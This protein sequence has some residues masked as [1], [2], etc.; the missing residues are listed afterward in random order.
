VVLKGQTAPCKIMADEIKFL[1]VFK[2]YDL[3]VIQVH[4]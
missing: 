2:G 1:E 3:V 4:V